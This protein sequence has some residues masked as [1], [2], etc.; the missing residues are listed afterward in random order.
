MT[1][2]ER[3]VDRNKNTSAAIE[4]S[5]DRSGS[6][7]SNDLCGCRS[8]VLVLSLYSPQLND[9]GKQLGKLSRATRLPEVT[10]FPNPNGQIF[11]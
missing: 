10:G 3:D 7:T 6:G 4:Y 5:V 2:K 11:G 9:E 8:K 1:G